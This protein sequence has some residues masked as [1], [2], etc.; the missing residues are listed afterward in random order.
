MPS[1]CGRAW[2]DEELGRIRGLLARESD[3]SRL[4]LSRL[5]C[6]FFDWRAP[7]GKLKEMSARVAMLAMHRDGLIEL[8]PPRRAPPQRYR[9]VPTA[10]CDPQ[11]PWRGAVGDLRAL[12]IVPVEGQRM[13]RCWN[14]FVGRYHYL[15]Y[16]MLAGAQLRYL[17]RDGAR[18]LGAM[19]FGA[20]AWKLAPRDR[21]IG[22]TPAQRERG[23]HRIVG[24]SR[25]LILPWI[26]CQNLASKAL[27][28][29][30]RRLGEDWQA[31][32][33]FR[34]ALLETFVDTTRFRGTCYRAANWLEVGHT[35]GRGKLDRTHQFAQ[36][37]KRI[38][39]K[40]LARD[41]REQL[42]APS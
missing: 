5:L 33:G 11:P 10:E 17:I 1:Y 18:V 16:P 38:Y 31:H 25:F 6:E 24:Q 39:L 32:Y 15:G 42:K 41:F 19:G 14:E 37:V 34:P 8:P 23:L 36:S 40:A 26:Q 20:A 35:Q 21:F 30:V 3:A 9:L 4:R 2:T 12:A 27:A 7:N 13:R 29:A 28:L 22:W